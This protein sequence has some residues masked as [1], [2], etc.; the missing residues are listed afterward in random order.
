RGVEIHVLA[1]GVN[2]VLAVRLVP[3][4]DRRSLVHILDDL[5]P[6]DA[7]VV[8]AE[9]DLAELRGIGDDA[10][11]SATEVVIEQVLEPH[12]A[13]DKEVPRKVAPFECILERPVRA[14][15]PV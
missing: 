1:F 6:T 3:F 14:A 13:N 8:G 5:P 11:L 15:M 2:F 10:P 4:R 7:G 12:S 9:G